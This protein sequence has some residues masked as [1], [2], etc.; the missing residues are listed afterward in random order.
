[1]LNNND[2]T[3]DKASQTELNLQS[4]SPRKAALK[5][6]CD[7]A[8]KRAKHAKLKCNK[9]EKNLE[10]ITFSDF[11]KLLYK[12]YPKPIADFIKAQAHNLNK[13]RNG[14]TY[15]KEFKMF[16]L[17]LY[18]KGPKVYKF[19]SNIYILP[20]KRTLERTIQELVISSGLHDIIF[21]RLR[22]KSENLPSLDKYCCI[23]IDMM[24]LKACLFYIINRDIVIGFH[25][26]GYT[27]SFLTACNAAIIMVR[28]STNKFKQPLDYFFLNSAM[29]ADEFR[30]ITINCVK[31]LQN[32]NLRIIRNY[33]YGNRLPK[34]S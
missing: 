19:L 1:M 14:N 6:K 27:K 23:N 32:I 22:I 13:K 34:G 20:S 5:R 7:A 15:T 11:Q 9:E 24:S 16:L 3:N 29:N 30:N 26:T 25:D 4:S 31:K 28:G 10:D 18:F 17:S 12:F 2:Q 21:E 8:E 33:R